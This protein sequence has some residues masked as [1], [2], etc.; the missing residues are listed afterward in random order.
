M[1][2]FDVFAAAALTVFGV[3]AASLL[4]KVYAALHVVL[5]TY[6]G[7]N[8]TSALNPHDVKSYAVYAFAA[9]ILGLAGAVL[10]GYVP[11]VLKE[12]EEP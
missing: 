2:L 12:A 6:S 9:A 5:D 11:S 4:I 8:L 1:R 3:V 10:F 7:G